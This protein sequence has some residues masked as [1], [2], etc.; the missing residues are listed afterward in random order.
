MRPDYKPS[1]DGGDYAV[2]GHVGHVFTINGKNEKESDIYTNDASNASNTSNSTYEREEE[3]HKEKTENELFSCE[4]LVVAGGATVP[5]DLR[6]EIRSLE[7][8]HTPH[9][10]MEMLEDIREWTMADVLD[11]R[12]RLILSQ[13]KEE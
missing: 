7:E 10:R 8:K 12:D 5:L 11:H 1:N 13:K 4:S 6:D 2:D 3:L 9:L